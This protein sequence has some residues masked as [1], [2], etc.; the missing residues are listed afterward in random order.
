[1]D[2]MHKLDRAKLDGLLYLQQANWPT[3]PT[4]I[5]TRPDD[6][7]KLGH[8][9]STTQHRGRWF[10]RSLQTVP[11]RYQ[12]G[13]LIVEQTALARLIEQKEETLWQKLVPFCLQPYIEAS[14]SGVILI[15]ENEVLVEFSEGIGEILHGKKV[16]HRALFHYDHGQ[17]QTVETQIITDQ[18]FTDSLWHSV[19]M[20]LHHIPVRELQYPDPR[21]AEWVYAPPNNLYYLDYQ[22]MPQGFVDSPRPLQA[23][24]KIIYPGRSDYPHYSYP[25]HERLPSSTHLILVME[26][27]YLDAITLAY[28]YPIAGFIARR[29]AWLSHLCRFASEQG[30]Y[31]AFNA[32]ST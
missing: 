4:F 22:S 29:G 14:T 11:A 10:L 21:I 8:F 2:G 19:I 17:F 9:Y 26:Q 27:P 23:E 7:H 25:L 31:C 6:L 28:Q 12:Q 3:P 16:P 30:F 15:R 24:T 20:A 1:M 18:P 5:A 32:D 13:S